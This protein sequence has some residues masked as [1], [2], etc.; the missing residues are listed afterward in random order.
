MPLSKKEVEHIAHLARI[1]LTD[2]ELLRFE[3]DIDSILA[4]VGELGTLDVGGIDPLTGGTTLENVLREDVLDGS[5]R[6]GDG[7]VLTRASKRHRDGYV[8]TPSVFERS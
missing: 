5:R 7:E 6:E 2:T 3:K 4:F 8:F 1:R